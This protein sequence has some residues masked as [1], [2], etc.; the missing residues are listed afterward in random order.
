MIGVTIGGIYSYVN[1]ARRN[2]DISNAKTMYDVCQSLKANETLCYWARVDAKRNFG[3]EAIERDKKGHNELSGF[4]FVWYNEAPYILGPNDVTPKTEEAKKNPPTLWNAYASSENFKLWKA[5]NN[6]AV[7]GLWEIANKNFGGLKSYMVLN[8]FQELVTDGLPA[9]K[10]SD[11]MF[12]WVSMQR[13][14]R[15]HL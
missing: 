13:K 7:N 8:S 10:E 11:K 6:G 15:I 14:T 9:C 1:K 5:Q 4:M 12:L 3:F 2:T